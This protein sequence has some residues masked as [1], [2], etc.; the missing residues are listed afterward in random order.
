MGYFQC[1]IGEKWSSSITREQGLLEHKQG[2]HSYVW[3]INF[4]PMHR[5]MSGLLQL[6]RDILR[7]EANEWILHSLKRGLQ[8]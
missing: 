5:E 7:R 1:E 2:I 6:P 3:L 8:L 4:N